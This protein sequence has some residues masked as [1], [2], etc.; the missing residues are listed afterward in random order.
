MRFTQRQASDAANQGKSEVG[1]RSIY[2]TCCR[3]FAAASAKRR[4]DPQENKA[5]E[6]QMS[7]TLERAASGASENRP[8]PS[9]IGIRIITTGLGE[10]FEIVFAGCV[11]LGA[12]SLLAFGYA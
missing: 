3:V 8:K 9:K 2:G 4:I 6:G 5:V 1:D 10:G 12:L 7:A 11:L